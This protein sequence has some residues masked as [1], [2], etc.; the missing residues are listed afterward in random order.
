M[1][2]I[3]LGETGKRPMKNELKS[4]MRTDFLAFAHKAILDLDG[5]KLDDDQYLEY[6]AAELIEFIDGKT[7][8]LLIN[9]PPRHLKTLLSAVCLSAWKF[10][11]QPSSKIMIVTYSEQLAANIARGVRG[12]LQSDWFKEV[13]R[14]RVAKDHSAVMDFATTAGGALYA[15]SLGGSITGRGADVIIVDD[16]HDIKDAGNLQQ[17]ERTIGLFETVVLSRLNNRRTGKV[18]V[19]AH[20]IHENDCSGHLLRQDN[21]THVVLPMV[22]IRDAAYETKYGRWR[23]R[24]DDLLRPDAFDPEDIEDLKANTHNPD[25]DMLYQQDADSRALPPLADDCFP[26]FRW[27]PSRRDL[28]CVMSVDAGM[29]PGSK[30]SFSGIQIWCPVGGDNYLID[31]WREQCDFKELWHQFIRYFRR[32]R[33]SAV[34]IEKAANGHALISLMKPKH[35]KLIHEIT[36]KG[37]KTA[38]LRRHI[39][40]ILAHR[41]LLPE[42]AA[43]RDEFVAEFVE[44]PHGDF[45]DQVDA[46][47]QYLDWKP[48]HPTLER[49]LQ[50]G[51]CVGVDSKGQPLTGAPPNAPFPRIARAVRW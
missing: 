36:P 48:A 39:D 49:P 2:T 26:S 4:L 19:I 43:W 46:T 8:R 6:L 16:P 42:N 51:L 15:V 10:G 27:P 3:H 18:I 32:H 17:L 30:N 35:R 29:T 22:A 33:P 5:T 25:F 7:R 31:Q 14:T 28:A 21:W 45:T 13:F 23:R 38:R 41:I 50:P 24:K 40:T 47:T 1:M 20:R 37:S 9:L 34:L 44:F 11:H 12:I